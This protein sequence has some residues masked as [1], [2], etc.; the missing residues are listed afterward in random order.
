MN[1]HYPMPARA[2]IPYCCSSC[3]R[4]FVSFGAIAAG[5]ILCACGAPLR[6]RPLQ[7]GLYELLP[8]VPDDEVSTDPGDTPMP[9]EH[10]VGY[11][12]SHGHG[13]RARGRHGERPGAV[14]T[15][16]AIFIPP[17]SV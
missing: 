10:D 12:T 4:C 6:R 5:E 1:H 3:A 17:D 7:R 9:K 15:V 13:G 14:K 2:T 11:G 16:E 8:S